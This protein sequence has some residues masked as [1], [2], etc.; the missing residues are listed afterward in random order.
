M[1]TKLG[2]VNTGVPGVFRIG[3]R[4]P[5]HVGLAAPFSLGLFS[6][7][8]VVL[9]ELSVQMICSTRALSAEYASTTVIR[10][11]ILTNGDEIIM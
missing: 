1:A 2:L 10:T 7:V 5:N 4:S 8:S 3:T 11:I 6:F 9:S